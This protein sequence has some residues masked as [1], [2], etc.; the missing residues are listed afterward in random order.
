MWHGPQISRHTIDVCLQRTRCLCGTSRIWNTRANH[1][2]DVFSPHSVHGRIG[3]QNLPKRL[4]SNTVYLSSEFL[5][6]RTLSQE[7]GTE[8]FLDGAVCF[9]EPNDFQFQLSKYFS[10]AQQLCS[11]PLFKVIRLVLPSRSMFSCLP[12]ALLASATYTPKVRYVHNSVNFC[13]WSSCF[14]G[15]FLSLSSVCHERLSFSVHATTRELLSDLKGI[16]YYR[17]MKNCGTILV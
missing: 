1:S 6:V 3:N 7:S 15:V 12:P 5:H 10:A 9:P 8:H 2:T 11:D 14:L 4:S 17:H 16:R 13:I